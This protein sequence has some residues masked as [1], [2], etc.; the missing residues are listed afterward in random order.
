[1]ALLVTAE[2]LLYPRFHILSTKATL[3]SECRLASHFNQNKVVSSEL[4]TEEAH[5]I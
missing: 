4:Y 5:I 1:M 2:S 3:D